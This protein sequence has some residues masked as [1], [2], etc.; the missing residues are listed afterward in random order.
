MTE[1]VAAG[2]ACEGGQGRQGGG[3]GSSPEG[4][5]GGSPLPSTA[6]DPGTHGVRWAPGV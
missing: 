2:G 6:R 5:E 1:T 4:R 3:A